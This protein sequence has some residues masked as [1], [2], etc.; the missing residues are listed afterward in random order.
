MR[1]GAG[2]M[3]GTGGGRGGGGR[4]AV[5]SAPRPRT[6]E[7][8]SLS[9][10]ASQA[11]PHSTQ[12]QRAARGAGA[13]S[14]LAGRPAATGG[15]V[16]QS[17]PRRPL[18]RVQGRRRAPLLKA[19][20][21][22]RALDC[23]AA[24]RPAFCHTARTPSPRVPRALPRGVAHQIHRC[25]APRPAAPRREA[26]RKNAG[27]AD[28]P[29]RAVRLPRRQRACGQQVRGAPG[30]WERSPPRAPREGARGAQPSTLPSDAPSRAPCARRGGRAIAAALPRG[31]PQSAA[32]QPQQQQERPPAQGQAQVRAPRCERGRRPGAAAAQPR[33]RAATSRLQR[34]GEGAPPAAPRPT[35]PP[36]APVPHPAPPRSRRPAGETR[37]W[38]LPRRSRRC[39]CRPPAPRAR[40]RGSCRRW[41]RQAR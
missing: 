27:S 40:R 9:G 33:P 12:P 13:P 35:P 7:R 16:R 26:P 1:P 29:R 10:R 21:Q 14:P 39:S 32:Q 19:G 23:S 41:G 22:C 24:T 11:K 20:R 38:R 15:P 37:C 36:P 3:G 6:T 34:A 4:G 5:G 2:V 17:W 18:V 25:A 30:E 28:R 31:A 8:S